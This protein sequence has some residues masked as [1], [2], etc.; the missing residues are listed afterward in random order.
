MNT[1]FT[2]DLNDKV[3]AVTGGSG[4]L[5]SKMARAL[6]SCGAK[7]AILGASIVEIGEA[8]DALSLQLQERCPT[9]Q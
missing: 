6:A 9:D 1:P 7:V 3:A 2:V 8:M 5:C 4:V